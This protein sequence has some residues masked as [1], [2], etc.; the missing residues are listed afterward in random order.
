MLKFKLNE[1]DASCK[2]LKSAN[3][4]LEERIRELEQGQVGVENSV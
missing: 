3:K 4:V 1:L 2:H